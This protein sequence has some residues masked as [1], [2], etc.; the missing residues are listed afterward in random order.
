MT[1][2]TIPKDMIKMVDLIETMEL[3]MSSALVLSSMLLV[4]VTFV[5]TAYIAGKGTTPLVNLNYL[6]HL[7]WIAGSTF[8]FSFL[9]YLFSLLYVLDLQFAFQNSYIYSIALS[10]FALSL[11]GLI[12][13]VTKILSIVNK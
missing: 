9:S 6:R 4:I 11:I 1:K 10:L 3:V 2:E 12:V 8:M 7:A 5:V 13:I